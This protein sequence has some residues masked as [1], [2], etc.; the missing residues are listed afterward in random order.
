MLAYAIFASNWHLLMRALGDRGNLM[1][2]W[3]FFLMAQSASICR[4]T[5]A[6]MPAASLSELKHGQ[7]ASHIVTT[8]VDPDHDGF[9]GGWIAEPLGDLQVTHIK[10]HTRIMDREGRINGDSCGHREH[11]DRCAHVATQLSTL[12]LAGSLAYAGDKRFHRVAIQ[13]G[14][15]AHCALHGNDFRGVIA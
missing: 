1:T 3:E 10:Q 6:S 5:S 12:S 13:A 14:D 8:D 7:L 2:S 15:A 11:S 4:E 9:G